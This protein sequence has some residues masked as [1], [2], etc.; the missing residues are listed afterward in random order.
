METESILQGCITK[1]IS[2]IKGI[3]EC[4]FFYYTDVFAFLYSLGKEF[5]CRQMKLPENVKVLKNEKFNRLWDH[6][7]QIM[8]SDGQTIKSSCFFELVWNIKLKK[9]IKDSAGKA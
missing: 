9:N 3:V 2:I 6:R 8:I 5:F 1:G 7:K 4:D